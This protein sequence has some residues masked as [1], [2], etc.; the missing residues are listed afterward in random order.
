MLSSPVHVRTA[1]SPKQLLATASLALAVFLLAPLS[2]GAV[3]FTLED[4]SNKGVNVRLTAD[5]TIVGDILTLVLTNDS[6]NH[7]GGASPSLNPDDLLTSFYFDVFNGVSRPTLTYATAVGDVCTV[8]DA[9]PDDCSLVDKENDLRAFVAKDGTWQF[10]DG[11]SQTAGASTLTFG[12]GTAG[13]NSLMP[14]GFMGNIVGRF[15]YGIYAGD[16][17]TNN[18][19]N[20]QPLATESITFTWSGATGFTDADIV[21]KVLFGLGTQPDS[22]HQAPEPGA[23]ALLLL[24]LGGLALRARGRR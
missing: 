11:L 3:S 18:L 13:N 10:R 7:S 5:L 14:N 4:Q 17:T 20:F 21:D 9:L 23:V 15:D 16:V 19:E 6:M 8:D 12:V 24:G 1:V 2:A 22:T